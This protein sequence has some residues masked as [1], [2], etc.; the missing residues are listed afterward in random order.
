MPRRSL[1]LIDFPCMVVETGRL[2]PT[3]LEGGHELSLISML[4]GRETTTIAM[5]EFVVNGFPVRGCR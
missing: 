5:P 1:S 2:S 3:S 4:V